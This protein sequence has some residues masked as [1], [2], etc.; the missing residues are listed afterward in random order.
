MHTHITLI[1]FWIGGLSAIVNR[2][3]AHFDGGL[4][5]LAERMLREIGTPYSA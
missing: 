1:A 2:T 4:G 3:N 5:P